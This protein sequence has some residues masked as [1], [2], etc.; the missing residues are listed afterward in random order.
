[1]NSRPI[2]EA[3]AFIGQLAQP[4]AK[5]RVRRSAGTV[6]DHLP[7]RADD[8]AGPTFRQAHHG[9]QMRDG[10][11]LHGPESGFIDLDDLTHRLLVAHRLLLHSMK[12]PAV[13]KVRKILYVIA[14]L[15]RR[16]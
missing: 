5:F 4:G 14:L 9:P 10:V 16:G 11:A 8:A 7:V 15:A 1:M 12:K 6:A 13:L 3:A 2:A